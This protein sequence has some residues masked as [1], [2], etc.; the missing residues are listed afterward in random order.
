MR[1]KDMDEKIKCLFK[2]CKG[3]AS[4]FGYLQGKPI[5]ICQAHA[6]TLPDKL[7]KKIVQHVERTQ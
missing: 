1:S 2:N 3:E 6:K 4:L 5:Y 7:I